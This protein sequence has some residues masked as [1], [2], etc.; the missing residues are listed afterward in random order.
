MIDGIGILM[1]FFNIPVKNTHVNRDTRQ[2]F[3]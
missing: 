3:R 1:E 2:K